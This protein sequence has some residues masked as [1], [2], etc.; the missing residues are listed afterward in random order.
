MFSNRKKTV[1]ITYKVYTKIVFA[2][3]FTQ[4]KEIEGMSKIIKVILNSE[5]D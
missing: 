5:I 4:I 1:V 2:Q 3:I